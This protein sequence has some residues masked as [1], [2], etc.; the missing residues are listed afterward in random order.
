[1]KPV[2]IRSPRGDV[3]FQLGIPT[4][5]HSGFE[6]Q[7]G[8]NGCYEP[9]LTHAEAQL[10]KGM[11]DAAFFDVGARWGYHSCVAIEAGA[12]CVAAFEQSPDKAE[13]LK[14]N[15]E[16]QGSADVHIV[17]KKV[18]EDVELDDYAEAEFPPDVVKTDVEGDEY[19]VLKGAT[20]TLRE[21]KPHLFV[22]MHPDGIEETG[23]T[24][25]DLLEML[26]SIGY[27]LSYIGF[28]NHRSRDYVDKWRPVADYGELPEG[29]ID[30][31]IQGKP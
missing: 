14:R 13:L 27:G 19:T 8:E 28:E 4:W 17:T 6:R 16:S 23:R 2:E 21:A 22:E 11:R 26:E 30:Y 5:G 24:Q 10:I 20:D 31:L 18:G 9:P 29:Q 1:M 12:S 7:V 25:R 15:V 3:E